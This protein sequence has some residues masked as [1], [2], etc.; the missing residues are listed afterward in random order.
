M[1]KEEIKR[2]SLCGLFTAFIAASA[3]ISIYMPSGVN[4]TLQTLAV[5]L[6]G[7]MLGGKYALGAAAAY[8]AIGACGLPVFSAFTG[9][10][11][12]LFGLSGGFLFGF[13]T[14]AL[15]CGISN[16]IHK[17]PLKITLVILAVLLCHAV[18]VLQ[19]CLLSGVGIAEGLI[20]CSLPYLPKDFACV[21]AA[22]FIKQKL[23]NKMP[24]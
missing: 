12:V 11:G 9:G 6:S 4:L 21:A 2:I 13:L 10:V 1:R 5:A 14:L 17:K 23:K 7:F 18:G 8:I 16:T 3:Q 19:F 22:Y 15:L 24:F 20:A